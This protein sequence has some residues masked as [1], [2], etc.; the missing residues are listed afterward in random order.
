MLNI[1]AWSRKPG[2]AL[3][4]F[5]DIIEPMGVTWAVNNERPASYLAQAT[6]LGQYVHAELAGTDPDQ[7]LRLRADVVREDGELERIEVE[8]LASGMV[9]TDL[10]LSTEMTLA[11]VDADDNV[12]DQMWLSDGAWTVLDDSMWGGATEVSW[13]SPE[14]CPERPPTE[15]GA[16][17]LSGCAH[18][19]ADLE[20]FA[21]VARHLGGGDAPIDATGYDAMR[22]YIESN[23]PTRACLE[24]IDG[25]GAEHP[26]LRLP[27]YPDGQWV[28][29]D[30]TA[31][32]RLD[33]CEPIEADGIHLLSF[34]A[35]APGPL[36]M[37]VGG[38]T[39]LPSAAQTDTSLPCDTEEPGADDDQATGGCGCRQEPG[40]PGMAGMLMMLLGL[41]RLRRRG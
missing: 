10:G 5:E 2:F 36:Q 14:G 4:L 19:E 37:A 22:V 32:R 1:Q 40:M 26:C 29:L 16:L 12:V 30:L 17:A 28:T 9:D 18:L 21:G 39:L 38:L 15:E 13:F 3:T 24:R 7:Q 41:G 33:T 35:T 20:Q 31:A 11:L 6:T 23:Q 25:D 27:A 34:T 8:G